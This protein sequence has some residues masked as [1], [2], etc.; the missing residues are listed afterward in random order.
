MLPPS[1]QDPHPRPPLRRQTQFHYRTSFNLLCNCVLEA[2]DIHPDIFQSRHHQLR[3]NG[4]I[5]PCHIQLAFGAY[6]CHLTDLPVVEAREGLLHPGGS[7]PTSPTQTIAPIGP[8]QHIIFLSSSYP[9]LIS[10]IYLPYT[11]NFT[12]P[13]TDFSPLLA[14]R[15]L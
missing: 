6:A 1:L 15:L 7:S 10:P 3:P 9:P 5:Y 2:G 14:S 11:P 13:V 12:T 8:P 4:W